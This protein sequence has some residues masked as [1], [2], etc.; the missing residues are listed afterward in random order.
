[1]IVGG[2]QRLYQMSFQRNDTLLVSDVRLQLDEALGCQVEFFV[3][4]NQFLEQLVDRSKDPQ[5]L[6]S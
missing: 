2:D 3:A 6:A 1:M 5:L 4:R